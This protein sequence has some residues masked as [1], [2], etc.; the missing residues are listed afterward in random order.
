MDLDPTISAALLVVVLAG[1]LWVILRATARP[2]GVEIQDM[3]A[4]RFETSWPRG[5]QEEDL[6]RWRIECLTR[7]S[8]ERSWHPGQ[9]MIGG[10]PVS[11]PPPVDRVTSSK[12]PGRA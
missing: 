5:V 3:I 8:D 10:S 11:G 2:G 9:R 12:V 1:E 6:V 4:S 7:A